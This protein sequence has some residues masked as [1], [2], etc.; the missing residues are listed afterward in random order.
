LP[1]QGKQQANQHPNARYVFT[2]TA[3]LVGIAIPARRSQI[4]LWRERN[5]IARNNSQK[6]DFVVQASM[7]TVRKVSSTDILSNKSE[8]MV[9]LFS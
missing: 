9:S 8:R 3:F 6:Y 4:F 5:G 2:K 7:Y 1:S